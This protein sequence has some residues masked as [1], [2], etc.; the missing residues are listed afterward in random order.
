VCSQGVQGENF[1]QG[2]KGVART[3]VQRVT[4]FILLSLCVCV[5]VGQCVVGLGFNASLIGLRGNVRSPN[6]QRSPQ[7]QSHALGQEPELGE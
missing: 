3:V 4:L 6:K 5:Q 1:I 2:V 7:A